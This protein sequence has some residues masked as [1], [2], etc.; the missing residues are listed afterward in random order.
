MAK[1]ARMGVLCLALGL[2]ALLPLDWWPSPFSGQGLGLIGVALAIIVLGTLITS[3][4]RLRH[5][6]VELLPH[7]HDEPQ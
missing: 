4:I 1:P 3:I 5:A 2:L 7:N 6:F